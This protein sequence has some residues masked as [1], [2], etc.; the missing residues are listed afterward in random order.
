MNNEP[1]LVEDNVVVLSIES[2]KEFYVKLQEYDKTEARCHK[3]IQLEAENESEPAAIALHDIYLAK[4]DE[5]GL[6]YRAQAREVHVNNKH[7]RVFFLDLGKYGVVK[8]SLMKTCLSVVRHIKGIAEKCSLVDK[9]VA[10][11]DER[12]SNDTSA[13]FKKLVSERLVLDLL[14]AVPNSNIAL[15]TSPLEN[16]SK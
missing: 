3:Q 15:I 4:Y 8:K 2:I 12:D 10:F 14:L 13:I 7:V 6:W 5:K 16:A 1:D 9:L 11:L